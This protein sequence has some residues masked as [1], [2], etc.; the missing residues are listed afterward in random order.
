[1]TGVKKKTLAPTVSGRAGSVVECGESDQR[2][3]ARNGAAGRVFVPFLG[4]MLATLACPTPVFAAAFSANGSVWQD[5]YVSGPPGTPSVSPTHATFMQ[6]Y[7]S[8]DIN[9]N[10]RAEASQG[11]LKLFTL[12]SINGMTNWS[13]GHVSSTSSA[14]ILEPVYPLWQFLTGNVAP[15]AYI[16]FEYEVWVAG[17]LYATSAGPGA[18][19]SEAGLQYSYR[20]GDSSGGGNWSQNSAGQVSKSGTWNNSVKGSFT[21]QKDSTFNLQL[22]ATAGGGGSKTYVPGSNA[23]V[24][25]IA[26]FSHTMTWLGIT[27]VRAFDSLGNEVQLPAD[28][29][30]PLIGRDSGFDYWHSAAG[31]AEVPEPAT[32]LL[33]VSGLVF[34]GLMRESVARRR[35]R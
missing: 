33:L 26:D 13:S 21:I 35:D 31:P 27:G 28:A 17:N 5:F 2:L 30:L 18:A 10:S 25:A 12:A 1:M 29:Y 16:T 15:W 32:V 9:L 14:G 7:V 22:A 8:A 4:L 19:G 24:V 34:A 3:P 6:Q 23:T 20:V 11:N